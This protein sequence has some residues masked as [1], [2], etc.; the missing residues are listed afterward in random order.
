MNKLLVTRSLS[1]E[2]SMNRSARS[3]AVMAFLALVCALPVSAEIPP[4]LSYQGVLTDLD[5]SGVVDGDYIIEFR[6]YTDAEGGS[7]IWREEQTVTVTKSIVNTMLG[8]GE[9][10]SALDFDRPYYLGILIEEGDEL[11][12][13]QLITPSAYSFRAKD[14]EDGAIATAKIRDEAVTTAKLADGAVT[15]AKLAE[16]IEIPITGSAG[17]DLTGTY[18]DPTIRSGVVNAAMLADGAVSNAK[19]QNNAVTTAKIQDGAVTQAKLASGVTL[20]PGGT[21]SGDLAGTYPGPTVAAIRGRSIST[22]TPATGNVLKWTGSNWAPQ[23]DGLSLPFTG[24]VS[25]GMYA[26]NIEH[27]ASTGAAVGGRFTV[28]SSSGYGVFGGAFG[29]SGTTYGGYFQ[30]NST[31]G[32]GLF[33]WAGATSGVTYG[34]FF[35][36]S[37]S[38]GRGVYARVTASTGDTYGAY[39]ENTSTTGAH[40]SHRYAVYAHAFAIS[41]NAYGG[42][43]GSS[44]THGAALVGIAYASSGGANGVYGRTWGPDGYGVYY[45]GG[46]GGHGLV[47]SKMD[48]PLDPAN[49][50]LNHFCSTGPEPLHAY[51]GNVV[52]DA[53]G[54]AVV[55]LP[56][57]FDSINRDLRYQ[58]TCIGGFAPV[59][60]AEK[61]RDNRFSIA[62]GNPGLEVSW[63]VE[64]VRD[65]LLVRRHGFVAEQ[66]K[67][68]EHRGKYLDPELYG[69]PREMGIDYLPE[70]QPVQHPEPLEI[71]HLD[72]GGW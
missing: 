36:S 61:V 14:V 30:N 10:L 3:F 67:P 4:L 60:I 15:Q 46:L 55:D 58:L 71:G 51:S 42:R 1:K 6:L 18:P 27:G 47:T 41:G 23:L 26:F 33:A 39:F 37:S 65:D 63:R 44:S 49:K 13:R 69:L 38:S 5:G 66:D 12:P 25:S 20:P 22:A 40:P 70:P 50:Y 43:F 32:R 8:I 57:Y 45:I 52:L 7:L 54:E 21:A 56:A 59:Y 31:S 35:E 62:G 48:H 24:S 2:F 19:I 72:H 17:G 64:A 11:A 29:A 16:G 9:P 68:A 34:G 28:S 53:R